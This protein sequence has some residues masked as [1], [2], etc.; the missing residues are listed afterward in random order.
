MQCDGIISGF[1]LIRKP[2]LVPVLN[3]NSEILHQT[4]GYNLC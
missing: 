1:G 3:W 2:K 4:L